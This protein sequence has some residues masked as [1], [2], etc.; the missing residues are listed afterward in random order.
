MQTARFGSLERPCC[1]R[2]RRT[3]P[4]RRRVHV[5]SRRAAVLRCSRAARNIGTAAESQVNS[6]S[7][8]DTGCPNAGSVLRGNH[9]YRITETPLDACKGMFC[10]PKAGCIDW[11]RDRRLKRLREGRIG[12]WSSDMEEPGDAT[13]FGGIGDAKS[14]D[15]GVTLLKLRVDA[16]MNIYAHAQ[17]WHS[18]WSRHAQSFA[19]VAHSGDP[20]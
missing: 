9:I 12:L 6:T 4:P 8:G 15:H 18:P 7:F 1:A 17:N 10:N 3:P 2:I 13:W 14:N 16:T 19:G 11:G 5:Q 20:F